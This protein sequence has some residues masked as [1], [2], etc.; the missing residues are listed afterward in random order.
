MEITSLQK[1]N[2]LHFTSSQ[3]REDSLEDKKQGKLKTTWKR[4]EQEGKKD[5]GSVRALR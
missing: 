2:L 4:K 3:V 5:T 1:L